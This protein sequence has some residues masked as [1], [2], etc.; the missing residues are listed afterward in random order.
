[1]SDSR[2]D[3]TWDASTDDVDGYEVWSDG[4]LATTSLNSYSDT[5]LSASTTYDYE[6][7]AFDAAGNLSG[8]S[9]PASATTNAAA[10]ETIDITKAT[11]SSRKRELKVEATS[12]LGGD[13][14]TSL[15]ASFPVGVLE[16]S[17]P[18]VYNAG[19]D[20]WSVTFD[21]VTAKPEKVKVCSTLSGTCAET[22]GI[23]GR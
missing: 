11:Y 5:G 9:P 8:F 6:V 15:Q 14:D 21:G 16:S 2:I 20:K 23:G 7:R 12:S 4:F 18:M 13:D 3:L 1:M 19:K 22:T 17:K 10:G